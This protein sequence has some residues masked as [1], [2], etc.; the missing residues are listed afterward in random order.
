MKLSS[1][2]V[3]LLCVVQTSA[4]STTSFVV[5]SSS[6]YDTSLNLFGGKKEGGDKGPGMM[7]QLAMLKKAQ[8]VASKKMALDKELAKIE[9]VGEA[10]DGKVTIAVKYVPPPPMQQPS[11]EPAS[12]NIDEEYL[13]SASNE[14]IS[15]AVSEAIKDG[16]QKATVATAAK[17]QELTVELGKM[18]GE[19]KSEMD[20]PPAA[21]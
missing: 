5:N 4:F 10:A 21:A 8:E 17:M 14:D 20:S 16:Y 9:H 11:Y 15:A 13:S 12:C 18:M 7:D 2:V 6:K 3:A 1:C 19:M